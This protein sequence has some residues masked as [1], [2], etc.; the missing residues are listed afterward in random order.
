TY[1]GGTINPAAGEAISYEKMGEWTPGDQ[2]DM[3]IVK[4]AGAM[5]S[6]PADLNRFFTALF[7]G[8]V[9]KPASL[10]KMK[11]IKGE[12]GLGLYEIPLDEHVF[13]GHTGGIDGYNSVVGFLPGQ[14][15]SIAFSFNARDMAP[16]AILTGA[17]K[18]FF[19]KDYTIP[20]FKTYEVTAEDLKQ[21]EG[22]YSNENFPLKLKIYSEEGKLMGQA[23][24]QPSFPLEAYEK[25]KFK[26]D[27]FGLK[28]EFKPAENK[29]IFKQGPNAHELSRA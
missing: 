18:I 14:G 2:T 22:T 1:Y 11:E 12:F 5:I 20:S 25:D 4:G 3:S 19:G 16:H 13:Y 23:E 28:L 7:E 10:E 8:K 27:R 15:I 29:M 21:Y 24:G 9:V 17:A 6:T 26:F